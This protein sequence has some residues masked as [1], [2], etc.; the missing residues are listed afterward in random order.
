[1]TTHRA[2]TGQFDVDLVEL[3]PEAL[4][5]LI[6]QGLAIKG[7]CVLNPRLEPRLLDSAVREA[8]GLAFEQVSAEV[9]EGLLGPEGSAGIAELQFEAEGREAEDGGLRAVERVVTRL[10]D[11]LQPYVGLVDCNFSYRSLAVVHRAGEA[12]EAAPPLHEAEVSKWQAQFIRHRLM[13]VIFLG[14]ETGSLV[15]EPFDT[16]DAEPYEMRTAPGTMVLL[17]ADAVS[18]RHSALGDAY[19]LSSFYMTDALRKRAP[20]GGR[21]LVPAARAIEEWT[22]L[23]LW[24]LKVT[25]EVEAD[26]PEVWQR[27]AN[28][29]YHRGPL[30]GISGVG[31]HQTAA[32][33]MDEWFCAGSA[34]P[35]YAR[36]VPFTRW[37]HEE[38]YDP[39]RESWRLGKTYCRHGNFMDGLEL[40]DNKFFNLSVEESRDLDPH[41]RQILEQGY[42]ALAHM[43][44]TKKDLMNANGGVYVG[45]ETDEWTGCAPGAQG[46]RS[47]SNQLCMFCGRVSFC[48]NLKGP[49]MTLST[50]GASGLT[51]SC[52]AAESVQRRGPAAPL[53]F[54]LAIGVSLM[55]SPA[56]WATHSMHGWLSKEGRCLSFDASAD[57]YVRGDGCV[58][59]AMKG[60]LPGVE[61]EVAPND[62]E[63][64]LGS[65]AGAR[66]NHNGQA[67]SLT[68]PH[69]PS[70]QECV[71]Q[72]IRSAGVRPADVE[73]V[74]AHALGN[75]LGDAVELSSH[76]RAHRHGAAEE[77]LC[78][79]SAKSSVANQ[80]EA[81]GT[82]GLVKAIYAARWGRMLPSLHLRRSSPHAEAF[83][84]P[85]LLLSESADFQRWSCYAGVM[86]RGLGGTN[87]HVV[88]WGMAKSA[89]AA[90][91]PPEERPQ[92]AYWPGGG[93]RLEGELAPRASGAYFIVGSWTRW[94][95]PQQMER[96]GEG[97]YGFT[98][99]LGENRWEQFQIWLDGDASR[100]LHPGEPRM[101][102]GWPVRG[103]GLELE[104]G[105]EALRSGTAPTWIIDGRGGLAGYERRPGALLSLT[106]Q[107]GEGA[108]ALVDAES[109]TLGTTEAGQP[110]DQYRVLLQ[111]TGKW[112]MV[113]WEKLPALEQALPPLVPP[114]TYYLAGSWSDW[115]L[116]EMHSDPS[117]P[118]LFTAEVRLPAEGIGDFQVV[119]DR[120]WSQVFYPNPDAAM[121]E[122]DSV[123]GPDDLGFDLAWRMEGAPGDTFQVRFQRTH[124][125]GVESRILLWQQAEQL[126]DA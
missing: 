48:L 107:P 7:F 125:A 31:V 1:M 56:V 54:A 60:V 52:I 72:A 104:G 74:E 11:L 64:F 99:T 37:N 114:G 29:A 42:N 12:E 62:G 23:R 111:V 97:E 112:R 79:M 71:A 76:S 2:D 100:A 35:D 58:A 89:R 17:R 15:L 75:L 87:A 65:I 66:T 27:A 106:E 26:V 30:T 51:A 44:R 83:Q 126:A 122:P 124:E 16:E 85:L 41:Q 3:P 43:G 10:G 6:V 80:V 49:A 57:G 102:Q 108:E 36:E 8:E 34:G 88:T 117:S 50:E 55:L 105:V 68:A 120:D 38:Y 67:A 63:E 116:E 59:L 22:F 98:V 118:G 46:F 13:A 19:A 21:R 5:P 40:F 113:T 47:V 93:G 33:D 24:D 103:P 121:E 115:A 69:G 73:C 123:L 4:G 84:E 119:R 86:A 78:L 39:D 18:H 82:T 20:E 81:G 53:D 101:P 25:E 70:Q 96:E 94:E 9:A 95:E 90:P 77:P 32:Y 92:L 28:H 14:P 110:G 91:P 45:C 61:A 109:L